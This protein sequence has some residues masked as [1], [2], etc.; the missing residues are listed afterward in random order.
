[1]SQQ[2]AKESIVK[3]HEL[4]NDNT[5]FYREFND[6]VRG[7]ISA[8]RSDRNLSAEGQAAKV[9]E[10]KEKRGKELMQEIYKRRH[11]F[12][13]HLA[14]AKKHAEDVIYAKIPQPDATKLGRFEEALR[15]LKTEVMLAVDSK[16]AAAKLTQFIEGIDDPYLAH[17]VSEQFGELSGSILAIT[18][19]EEAMKMRLELSQHFSGLTA[20][21]ESPDATA[22]RGTLE[23]AASMDESAFF[24]ETVRES[25][26]NALGVRYGSFIN[27][28]DDYFAA[29]EAERP[30]LE[31]VPKK[32]NEIGSDSTGYAQSMKAYDEASRKAVEAH[33]RVADL[34][35]QRLASLRGET[36]DD[37]AQSE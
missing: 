34:L 7:E 8:V 2:K 14:D 6:K 10:I 30:I 9:K 19:K 27:N 17:K 28:T 36:S 37:A 11:E 12:R 1:M 3:A 18:P 29:N 35:E 26:N 32:T 21:Y 33:Q 23:S 15:V 31:Q 13:Q 5:R 16:T 22:A 20:K 25:V 4:R 24:I